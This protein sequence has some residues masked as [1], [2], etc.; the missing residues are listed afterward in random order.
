MDTIEFMTRDLE[1]LKKRI[2]DVSSAY[3]AQDAGL[4]MTRSKEMFDAFSKRFSLE[5]FLLSKFT[6]SEAMRPHLK[7]FLDKRRSLR[8]R[9]EDMLMMHVSE[10]DY[11][12]EVQKLIHAADEHVKFLESTF[13][14]EV[15]D[16]ISK[17]DLANMNHALEDRLHSV[18]L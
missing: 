10:P 11:I 3:E 2:H 8:E 16:K 1:L 15:I 5:D 6:P 18:A 17:D 13:H 12:K 9:L 4:T 7:A 14:P